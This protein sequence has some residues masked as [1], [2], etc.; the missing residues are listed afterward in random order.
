MLVTREKKLYRAMTILSGSLILA[1]VIGTVLSL[2]LHLFNTDKLSAYMTGT[3]G[4]NSGR[5]QLRFF[6]DNAMTTVFT[7][8]GVAVF[9]SMVAVAVLLGIKSNRIRQTALPERRGALQIIRIFTGFALLAVPVLYLIFSMYSF[10]LGK[11]QGSAN[12]LA[13]ILAVPASLYFLFPGITDRF[14]EF[15]QIVFGICLIGFAVFSLITTHVYMYEGLTSP[16][17]ACN[18]LSLVALMLFILYEVRFFA[19]KPLPNLYLACAGLALYFCATNGIPRLIA[20]VA[21]DMEVS[22]QTIYACMEAMIAMYAACRML[23]FLSE[24]KYALQA[25]ADAMEDL[26]Q[27][28]SLATENSVD[29]VEPDYTEDN[30]I[31]KPIL[32]AKIDL[33]LFDRAFSGEEDAETDALDDVLPDATDV[34]IDAL[35]PLDDNALAELLVDVLPTEKGENAPTFDKEDTPDTPEEP[36]E[37]TAKT[38]PEDANDAFDALT[39]EMFGPRS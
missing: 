16:I 24:W 35:D 32:T 38:V 36:Q 31:E 18:L 17:R 29:M 19:S 21:G 14:S 22:L 9:L 33:D 28:V 8:L 15:L 12:L 3:S 30:D 27:T 13:M 6:K 4:Y 10:E 5:I 7:V 2:Y 39:D 23:L 11:F 25:S 26:P 1:T 34:P 20:T 37:E